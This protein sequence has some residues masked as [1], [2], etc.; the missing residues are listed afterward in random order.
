MVHRLELPKDSGQALEV[1]RSL[2]AQAPVVV[3]KQ[4]PI[5]PIS[6]A[7]QRRFESWLADLPEGTELHVA[8][9]DVIEDRPLARGLTAAL[10]VKHES[11]QALVF[12]G[13]QLVW[14]DSHQ[15]LDGAA[16][17]AQLEA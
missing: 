3:F 4:S 6:H 12:R 17:S 5:C 1:L 14:H 8:R 11:P 16:F 13:G 9:I 15:A 2:S 10:D 7:A